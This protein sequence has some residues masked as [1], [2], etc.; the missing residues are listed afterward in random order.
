MLACKRS[1]FFLLKPGDKIPRR[2]SCLV[3]VRIIFLL[4]LVMR[5]A[6]C[7]VCPSAPP[8]GLPTPLQMVSFTHFHRGKVDGSPQALT[9]PPPPGNNPFEGR[10]PGKGTALAGRARGC[11]EKSPL[12]ALFSGK[13]LEA[14][15]L[16]VQMVRDCLHFAAAAPKVRFGGSTS[17]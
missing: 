16:Q 3:E 7:G 10:A 8:S 4:L 15:R 1:S 6:R 11:S 2:M 5:A 13:A 12:G 17:K 14:H 9:P